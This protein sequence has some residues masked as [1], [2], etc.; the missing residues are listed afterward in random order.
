MY[1]QSNR[2]LFISVL[3]ENYT[4]QEGKKV[5]SK[6]VP[7]CGESMFHLHV[8]QDYLLVKIWRAEIQLSD[9]V[10]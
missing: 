7:A 1:T 4:S 9:T 5:L 8:S 3:N 2:E 6:T 10:P